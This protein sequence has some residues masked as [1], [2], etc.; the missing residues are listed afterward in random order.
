VLRERTRG[1]DTLKT[2]RSDHCRN[3]SRV[4]LR[5]HRRV[6]KRS[7]IVVLTLRS[8]FSAAR[9]HHIV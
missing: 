6:R 7:R 3:S 4:S 5:R 9:G 8:G 2:G 1:W